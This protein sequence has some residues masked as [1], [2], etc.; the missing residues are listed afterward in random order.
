MVLYFI[1]IFVA[2]D[3]WI[4]RHLHTMKRPNTVYIS[5][6]LKERY[7]KAASDLLAILKKHDV[8]TKELVGTKD[9]WCRD[10]MPVQN[11]EGELIQF[12]YNPSYLRGK[13]EWEDSRSDVRKVCAANG[14]SP[15]FS[16]I[17]IDGGNVVL[18]GDKAIFTDRIFEEN[19][20]YSRDKLIS[21]LESVLKAKVIII[22]AIK[23]DVTGHADGMVRFVDND[24]ILGNDRSIDY[25]YIRDGI[26]KVCSENRLR[27]Q[28]VPFFTPKYDRKHKMSAIGI[29]VNFL[30]VD[31]LIVLPQ[32]NVEGNRDD[33]ALKC[34]REIY[35]DRI[36]ET[37]DYNEVALEGGLLNC[38][39][40]TINE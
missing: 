21:S 22:P 1:C 2:K 19:P 24:T 26:N 11:S 40:W 4:N 32:F 13:Q 14:I 23:T 20:D 10:Y 9:I 38:T 16:D 28:D 25:K 12:T 30:E 17:N 5:K 33:E 15:I 39:T 3:V 27:Y 18:F 6:L 31:D 36:I 8:T 7:P 35:P 34:F 37:I 29:Y